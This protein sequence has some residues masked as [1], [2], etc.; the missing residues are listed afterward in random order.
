[1]NEAAQGE[2]ERALLR[3]R[4]ARRTRRSFLIG[5][6]A[7]G[8]AFAAY[9]WLAGAKQIGQLES[10]LRRAEQFN[11]ALSRVLFSGKELAPTYPPSR[12][13]EL[14]LN[15][16]LGQDPNMLLDS[17]RLQLVGLEHPQQYRQFIEDV[18]L[19]Q[20]KSGT[21]PEVVQPA[22]SQDPKLRQGQ[23]IEVEQTLTVTIPAAPASDTDRTPGIVL[24]LADLSALP[25]TAQVTQFKCIEGWSQ[26]TSFGGARFSDFLKAYPPQRNPNGSLPRYVV[27]E[28][29]DGTFSSS[30]DIA[31]L[32][33]PQTLLCYQMNGKPLS[34]GHG[35]PLRLA[36]P[37]KYG[38]K[39]IKQVAKL[40]YTDQRTVD[41]WE[42][43]GY[44]WYAG[45]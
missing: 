18:D 25:F 32:L 41:F 8:T 17:W 23:H 11:A 22:L 24:S 6:V 5:G 10:P 35:A 27:M 7:A 45:L 40:T 3:Q 16:D 4:M 30:F 29:A 1:M 39:Q 2:T 43:L 9:E 33:H 38:Y 44:D 37:F 19:W 26:I 42:G 21:Q 34:P 20:Y 13:T 14:R 15:G 36:T 12:S 28:T 31:S